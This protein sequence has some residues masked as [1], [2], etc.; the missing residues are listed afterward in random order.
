MTDL[1]AV[2][3]ALDN[4]HNSYRHPSLPGLHASGLY[5]LFPPAGS[6]PANATWSWPDT[7]PDVENAGVYF[8]FDSK[9]TLLY[10]GKALILGRRLSEWFQY[11]ERGGC[12]VIGTWTTRPEY[13]ATVPVTAAFEASSL[14]EYLIMELCPPD[15]TA[16]KPRVKAKT[17]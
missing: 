11:G 2:Q 17:V 12:K 10:V 14:E 7:W 16:G 8:I 9:L 15:N 3:A 6:T 5:A 13:I 1:Q 4:Y